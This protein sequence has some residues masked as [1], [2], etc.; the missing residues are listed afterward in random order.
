MSETLSLLKEQG[1]DFIVTGE[2][3][4]QRPMSQRRDTLRVIERDSGAEGLLLRPLSAKLLKPTIP[5]EK[6]WV[7][8][9]LLLDFHGRGRK[10]QIELAARLGIDEYPSPAGGCLLTD[11][12]MSS[13]IRRLFDEN[14]T[15]KPEDISLL[16][17]GRPFYLGDGAVMTI[18]RDDRDNVIIEKMGVAG[19]IF[20]KLSHAMGPIGIIR[21]TRE[22]E[23]IMLAMS[24]L[25]RYSKSRHDNVVEVDAGEALDSPDVM[26]QVRPA[27]A[28]ECDVL[29]F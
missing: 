27:S 15:I 5:E 3:L 7:D 10:R 2:V 9:E 12:I 11:P 6:G 24:I 21:G 4:G 25:A 17:V 22:R 28:G 16:T 1:A 23:K 19:D 18:G 26:Y 20:L 13:R 8:R 14:K 29:K